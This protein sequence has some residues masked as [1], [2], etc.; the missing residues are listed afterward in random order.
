MR[1]VHANNPAIFRKNDLRGEQNKVK[2]SV[3]RNFSSTLL[4]IID[5]SKSRYMEGVSEDEA[6]NLA[7]QWVGRFESSFLA[8]VNSVD[9]WKNDSKTLDKLPNAEEPKR[10]VICDY[11]SYEKNDLSSNQEV[12]HSD[13]QKSKTFGK[14]SQQSEIPHCSS[15]RSSNSCS[16]SDDLKLENETPPQRRYINDL[17]LSKSENNYCDLEVSSSRSDG[18]GRETGSVLPRQNVTTPRVDPEYLRLKRLQ[19]FDSKSNNT[20]T[21]SD[22]GSNITVFDREERAL[23]PCHLPREIGQPGSMHSV[24]E[25]VAINPNTK[26]QPYWQGQEDEFRLDLWGLKDAVF[27]G[28]VDL[29]SYLPVNSNVQSNCVPTFST[30]DNKNVSL[31]QNSTAIKPD[32]PR[33]QLGTDCGKCNKTESDLNISSLKCEITVMSRIETDVLKV[34]LYES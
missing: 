4:Y 8:R 14:K 21:E 20:K 7:S 32:M 16:L 3:H 1:S 10:S 11:R 34:T 23:K 19:Y 27:T 24:D 22:E 30:E 33:C 15:F 17:K 9:C 31:S 18:H 25:C 2:L 29:D 26:L 12:F 6:R 5:E 13:C 28:Q